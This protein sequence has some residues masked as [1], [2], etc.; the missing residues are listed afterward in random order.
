MFITSDL[1]PVNEA[2]FGK[3]SKLIEIEKCIKAIR[4]KFGT[5]NT[6]IGGTGLGGAVEQ[7]A[8]WKRIRTLIEE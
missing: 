2:Y 3:A 5:S 7:S 8:E 1:H 4:A 6:L